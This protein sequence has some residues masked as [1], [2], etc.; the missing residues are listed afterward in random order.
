MCELFKVYHEKLK[1][2]WDISQDEFELDP[3]YIDQD[4]NWS[5]LSDSATPLGI[6]TMKTVGKSVTPGYEK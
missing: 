1:D 3:E 2:N 5:I 4:V 6:S